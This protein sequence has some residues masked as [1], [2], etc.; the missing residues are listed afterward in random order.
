MMLLGILMTMSDK[1][2]FSIDDAF[3]QLSP[4]QSPDRPASDTS[5]PSTST[6]HRYHIETQTTSD[7]V[8]YPSRFRVKV[9]KHALIGT[10]I[11][12]KG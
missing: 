1:N 12:Q 3:E 4:T 10:H 2:L 11:P 8:P 5:S 6:F 7:I 9:K